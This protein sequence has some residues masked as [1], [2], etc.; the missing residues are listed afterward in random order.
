MF[1]RKC[2]E[3]KYFVFLTYIENVP[4]IGSSCSVINR[5][6]LPTTISGQH[7]EFQEGAICEIVLLQSVSEFIKCLG[8]GENCC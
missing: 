6:K 7:S 5:K 2:C 3:F 4:K 8:L 1:K